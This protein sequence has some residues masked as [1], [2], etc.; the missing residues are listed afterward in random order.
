M[1]PLR[2]FAYRNLVTLILCTIALLGFLASGLSPVSGFKDVPSPVEDKAR[3]LPAQPDV[4]GARIPS[5]SSAGL[6]ERSNAFNLRLRSASAASPFAAALTATKTDSVSTPVNPGDTIMYTIEITNTGN[7]DATNVTLADTVDAN[8]T[9]QPGTI[10]LAPIAVD[11]TATSPNYHT[12]GNVNIVIAAAQGVIANDL[13]PNG[14]L[15]QLSVTKVGTTLP[16]STT[17]PPL[18]S[19]T[20]STANGSVTLSSD[21]SFT[22]TPNAGFEGTDTFTYTLDNGTGKTD[23]ATVTITVSG[24]IWFVNSAAAPGGDGRIGTP[25]NLLTGALSFDAVAA[26]DP[27]DN[28]FLY[29]GSYTGGLTLKNNQRLIG[30]GAS[31]TILVI[32]SL[33]APSGPSSPNPFPTTGGTD[34]T[35]TTAGVD[36][37]TLGTGNGLHG[38]TVGNTGAAGTD[39]AGTSFGTL[40]VRDVTVNGT[41]R[42]LNLTTGTFAAG[43]TFDLIESSGGSNNEGLRLSAVG[44]AFT[45]TTTNIAGTTGTGID[46]QSSPAGT[47]FN[48]GATTVNKSSSGTGV[49]LNSN[50]GTFTFSSLAVTTSSGTGVSATSSGTVNVTTG[51]I[52]ATGG[53]ALVVNPTT[54]GMTFTSV[55][56]SASTTTGISLTSVGGSLSIT[57]TTITNA[58]GIGIS[59]QTSAAGST[60]NFGNTNITNPDGD[61][62]GG[63]GVSLVN[64]VGAVTFAD[65]DITPETGQRAF[66]AT[67]NTG[68]I[69]TTSGTIS[70][71]N[72]TA[73]EIAG[74]SNVSR[75]PL[76]MTLTSVSALASGGSPPNGIFIQNTSATGSP[77]GFIVNA[78][79]LSGTSGADGATSG[80]GVRLE[81]ADTITL[82]GMTI[83]GTHQNFG[84][85]GNN[86]NGFT[87]TST[88]VTG[89][90][91]T[92]PA[93]DE[94]PVSFTNLL[95]SA[96]ITG[97]T[98]SGSVEDTFRLVNSSGTLN[99]LT[100]NGTTFGANSNTTGGDGAFIQAAGTS[101]VNVTIQN[102]FFTNARGDLI[103]TDVPAGT[104]N[105]IDLIFTGNTL[106]NNNTGIVS[107]GGGTTFSTT[108]LA[109][110]AFTFDISNNSFRDANGAALAVSGGNPGCSSSGKIQNNTVGVVATPNSGSL[111]GSGIAW[112]M[113]GG[114]AHAVNISGNSVRQCNNHG[115][116]LTMGD[117]MGNAQSGNA[118]ATGNTVSNPGTINTDFN[119][120]HLNHGTVATDTFS[121]CINIS[122]NTITGSGKGAV[123]P[124]NAEFRLRQRQMTT[125]SL[126]GYLGLNNEDCNV[127]AFIGGQ[128]TVSNCG[129]CGATCVNGIP[130]TPTKNGAASTQN[131]TTTLRGF[132]GGGACV[133][134]ASVT[135]D[136]EISS[137]Q[138]DTVNSEAQKAEL[139]YQDTLFA[140]EHLDNKG[141]TGVRQVDLLAA[142]HIALARFEKLGVSAEDIERL[143]AVQFEISDLPDDQLAI[144][145]PTMIKIDE[146]A[147]DYGWFLDPTPDDNDE[148]SGDEARRLKAKGIGFAF[149]RMDLLT[150]VSRSLDY[151][152]EHDWTKRSLNRFSLNDRILEPGLRRTLVG[153]I[154]KPAALPEPAD[155]VSMTTPAPADGTSGSDQFVASTNPAAAGDQTSQTE[156]TQGTVSPSTA[157]L[158]RKDSS[159]SL[160]DLKPAVFNPDGDLMPGSYGRSA[161]PVSYAT[162]APAAVPAKPMSGET[163]NLGPF[164]LPPGEKL[165]IMFNVTVNAANTLPPGTTQVCNQATVSATGIAAFG[166]NDPDTGTANDS[167]C[168]QLN[169]PP[170]VTT[171]PV[172]ASVCAGTDATF[173]A[174][175][176]GNPIPTVQWEVSTDG[177]STFNP[178]NTGVSN[179]TAGGIIT[180]TL[181]VSSVTPSQN[182][183]KYHAVFSNTVLPNATSNNAMLTVKQPP[184]ITKAF[185]AATIPLNGVTTL[186]LTIN[187]P[188]S[189]L[190]LT[191][192]AFSD[193][194]PAGLQVAATPGITSTCAGATWNASPGDTTLNFAGG[195]LAPGASCTVG[196]NVTG[197]TPGVKNNATNAPTSNECATGVASNTAMLTVI[198]PPTISKSFDAASI[199]LNGTSVLTFTITNPNPALALTG[200]A[201]S[202]TLPAGLT[203]PT[204]G[205][206]T[207]CGGGT[208]TTTSPS[209]ISF[210]GGSIAAAGN[211]MF[212]VTVTGATAGVK[213]NTT[214]T[215]SATESG[216]GGT[217]NTATITVVAPPS[218]SKSFN[219]TNIALNA[220]STLTFTITNP[221]TA[222]ALTGVGFTDTLPAG[223]TAPNTSVSQCGGTLTI[224]G[225]NLITLTGASIAASGTCMFNVTV[226][227]TTSG[228]KNNTTGNV[229]STNGGTGNTANATLS[230]AS[231]PT[232]SKAFGV[233]AVQLGGTTS[234]TFTITN[235]NSS[236]GLT[237]LSFTDVLPAGITVAS[238]GPTAACGGSV[239]TTAPST[240]SFTGGT[241]AA[242]SNCQFSVTVIGST[243]GVWN[244]TSGAI[245][246]TESGAGATSNTA[247]L[248]VIGPVQI[249]K[250]FDA[251][252]IPLN[253]TSVLTFT[254]TNPN[255]TLALTGVAFSDTLPAGLTVPTSGPTAVCGGSL[256]TTAPDIISF[257]GGTLAASANCQVTVTVTG[258]TAGVKNNTS[259]NVT[260]N[261]TGQGNTASASITVVA[262]PSIAKSFNPTNIPLN[263]TSTLTFTITNPNST[264]G[265]TGVGFTDVLPAGLTVATSGPTSTCGGSLTTTNPST[266]TLTGA[267]IAASGTCMFSVTVTGTTA[268]V[269]NNTTGAVTSTN[270]G[271]GNTASAMISVATAPSVNKAFGAS[272]VLLGGTTSLTFTVSNPNT[273]V[274]L[275][276]ISFTDTL[277]AGITVASSGPTST[278]GGTL[279]TT[280]PST[281]TFSGG[282]LLATGMCQ[283]GVTVTGSTTGVWNNTTGPVSSAESGAGATSNTATLTVIGPP[284]ISKAFD[285]ATIPVGGTSVLTFTISNPNTTTALTGVAFTDTLPAGLTVPTSGPTAVCGGTLT[286]TAPNTISFS[287]GSI[288][289]SSNCQIMVTVT[290]ATAGV[291]NNVS[292][293]VS[294]ANGGTGN[295][296]SANITVVAPP[297]IA[298]SF[299][300]TNIALNGTSTLTFT[301]TN[302]NTTVGLT[303]VGFTDTLPAG[304]TVATSGPTPTCGG[305]LTTTNPSTI[306]LTGAS[307]AASGTCMFSVT[308]TGTTAGVKNNTTGNVTSTN[309]GT[310]NTASATI[311]VATPP[312]I[313]KAFGASSVLLGGTTSLTF[314]LANANASLGLTGIAFTDTLPAGITVASSGPTPACGGSVT[315]TAP[316]TITFSGGSLAASGNC[317]FSVTV[318]GSTTG[319]WNNTTG[320]ISSNE[321][322]TGA[323]SN[324][325]TLTVIGPPSISKA[326]DAATIP[327]GGTSVLTFTV[328][329]PNTTTTL[330]GV[331]FSDTLPTGLTVPT[332]GPTAVCGGTLT[333]TA[334]NTIS[335]TGGSIASS[336][337]CLIT[338]TVT[339]A[340]AGV[341]NNVSDNVS[342]SNGGTGNTASASITVV[343][344]PS[345]S[346]Q[347]GAAVIPPNGTTSLTFTITNPNTTVGLTGVGFTDVLPAGLTVATSGPTATCGGNLT[348]TSPST[349]TLAGASIAANGTCTFSVTV[350]GTTSG[351]KNNTTGNVTSTNGG[352]GN[353][354]SASVTVGTPPTITCPPSPVTANAAPNQCQATVTFTVTATGVPDPTVTC[355]PPSGSVFPV[356][357]TT[358]NCNATNG[359]PPDASCSFTV[360]VNDTQPPVITCPPNK[361]VSTDPN[362]CSAV[363][364]YDPPI[365]T[366]NCPCGNNPTKK[367]AKLGIQ[368]A[369]MPVC[370]PASGSTFQ[371][372]TTTVTCNVSDAAGNSASC[373][374]TVT[375]NDTQPPAFPNGCIA[376]INATASAACPFASSAV[377]SFSNPAASDNCPGVTVSCNPPSGSMFP[378]G[379]TTVTCTAT[380]TS[381]NTA[382]CTTSVTVFGLCLQDDSSP[383]SVVLVDPVSGKYRYCCDGVLV[384]TGTGTV[385]GQGCVATIQDL[386]GD[387]K[388]LITV[389]TSVMRGTA[390]ITKG[391]NP[392]QKCLIQDRNLANNTCVCQ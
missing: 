321:S 82:S 388:V 244:N 129:G 190:T 158:R 360:R 348:T 384:A 339:G 324:T 346:K 276:N 270:G 319:V 116:L 373:T 304:L 251:A 197:T 110:S 364:T 193:N 382:T 95:G 174:A 106:S 288:A 296:A 112:V 146:T 145:T 314:T 230:V 377:V 318:T 115:I 218:I 299:N 104:N 391:N 160:L 252:T 10:K 8:V 78:G 349:I 245:S 53:P 89:T 352:T 180:S 356:G 49:N 309:G 274:D 234:L 130:A 65:L 247:T 344:P 385:N 261:E 39:I 337:N 120:I 206:T 141:A 210:S 333:T 340:T 83:N 358:V 156:N 45:A 162:A 12:I 107:G 7:M 238:S 368:A 214:G 369:C 279:T 200:I 189:G 133:V 273:A 312:T 307:I 125:V 48:F 173:T 177:G 219:P 345:I 203:V 232:L 271:T 222:V 208:L 157:D 199:P 359:I 246:S 56:S 320:P 259:G 264:V 383:G 96:S 226:T 34:P 365:V 300:P 228:V 72:N 143:R 35:I 25:F 24:M 351:V 236:L 22:Y 148:F 123:Y 322:G 117:Q 215:I 126:P 355:T 54:L 2:S 225:N 280:A 292:G 357:D 265:L 308:V 262:P 62:T 66:H 121:S 242:S 86:V 144:T 283:F 14:P 290:G 387:R 99:R 153:P 37:I 305:S 343:A 310:G 216:T 331:A 67:G 55:S 275:T 84:I 184:T 185:G 20:I 52:S 166:T 282:S 325:A 101:T 378:V 111:S 179:M 376:P 268:G 336:S 176:T 255:T 119:G 287:G 204:S 196:V 260:S 372:G 74:P 73:V 150:V 175:A 272:S 277:P 187:N 198:A 366:D 389:D 64:N 213:N 5:G 363:V 186:T 47:N 33:T 227:G 31:Q 379:T 328:S 71:T 154:H 335:F 269:K 60:V 386:K 152:L 257:T 220:T 188:N 223:L 194:L 76:N 70:T 317:Q 293:N 263:A 231:P 38:F 239:T 137:H 50:L 183:N 4:T 3:V 291:K 109:G 135:P 69:T 93:N 114:G 6:K 342:A 134:P 313:S 80:I 40:T 19:A 113:A 330:T 97:G 68:A 75:T 202:D 362:V 63:T 341:K 267:S 367:K 91:G 306:T 132:D 165:V 172:D 278:C 43:T 59:V 375:V 374:F 77:G 235:P 79:T 81:N 298:K 254:I 163:V 371:K 140:P 17:I 21:G 85:R 211:C 26:D 229:T 284:S 297:S 161:K 338:V 1:L 326:F 90:M 233:A 58:A 240:I 380:D 167:T 131:A 347:F 181:T 164:T 127:I 136:L 285:A 15:S 170:S 237:G 250:S 243:A 248:T 221:N 27:G 29:T 329:N 149:G 191:G 281:I 370:T 253:G 41:G 311:T 171:Q 61:T 51:S 102:S 18:G 9:L 212:T 361:T 295:T 159:I 301:I 315:T 392:A 23:T 354:A 36:A 241:L 155:K 32:T 11:D 88:S 195:T 122:T 169:I 98:F 118:S 139:V 353:T 57:T 168:T 289:A 103:Q 124:N 13:N 42:A 207:T 182:G 205:P 151:V 294:A 350:T 266:I 16:P 249:A 28:I 92:N 178:V 327:V 316:S 100:I 147:A 142:A 256:S 87:M 46:V 323:T 94:G 286:T 332:S 30:Q 201:F 105:K 390:F 128:N 217:S 224:T 138:N 381:G 302:P 303:G 209:T 192:I 334:P 258:A 44:G 108:G